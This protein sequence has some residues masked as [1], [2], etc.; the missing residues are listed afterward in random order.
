MDA[1]F[2][3]FSFPNRVRT[4]TVRMEVELELKVERNFLFEDRCPSCTWLGVPQL[5]P[6]C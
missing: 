1:S 6:I 4:F 3:N 5:R 2:G